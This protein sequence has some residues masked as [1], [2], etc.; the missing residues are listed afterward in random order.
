M[1]RLPAVLALALLCVAGQAFAAEPS[2][3]QTETGMLQGAS[4]RIDVPARWNH[5]LV[6]YFHGYADRPVVFGKHDALSPMFDSLL[7]RGYAVIQSG[8]SQGGWAVQQAAADTERLRKYFVSRHGAPTQ[9]IVMGM[10][11]GGA[12]TV[13]TI[14]RQPQAYAGALS[15]CGAIAPSD[16]L[17]ARAFA[18]RAAFDYY[19]PGLLGPLVPVPADYRND[20]QTTAKIAAAL[21]THPKARDAL[22]RWYGAADENNLA[23]VIAFTGDA[24]RELQRRAHGNPVGDVNLVYTGSGDDAALNDGVRRYRADPNAAAYL[25]RW[26]TPSGRLLRPMLELHDTGDPLV[27]ASS[28]YEYALAAQ[29]AGHG[30]QFVQQYVNHEGH[31]VFTPQQVGEAFGELLD[32][33]G[34]GRRP[35]PGRLP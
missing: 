12:L 1:R 21:R 19:F 17:M 15:L 18:L 32:W 22:L 24:M 16:Q 35:Q 26:Y 3:M 14:E 4:Y 27:P 5:K 29:R 34:H 8:Y 20:D 9:S 30:D 31:C 6:V 2:R 10:S 25:A 23:G 28:T 33:I 13:L 11:M 7:G